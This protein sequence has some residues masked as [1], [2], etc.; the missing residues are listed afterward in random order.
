MNVCL[1][2]L[3]IASCGWKPR[4]RFRLSNIFDLLRFAL[5]VTGHYLLH[6]FRDRS[7][8]IIVGKFFGVKLLGYYTVAADLS[9]I[10][11]E[12]IIVFVNKVAYPV[13]VKLQDEERE[14]K[15]YLLKLIYLLSSFCMPAMI[16]MAVISEEIFLLILS[17]KWL[18]G[19]LLFRLFCLVA[20]GQSYMGI[21][22]NVLKAKGKVRFVF[23]YSLISAL[24]MPLSFLI[25]VR[26]G[27]MGIMCAWLTVY[28][29]V[30]T[31]LSWR[32]MKELRISLDELL[33]P[34]AFPLIGAVI[35]GVFMVAFRYLILSS[36]ISFKGMMAS[37]SVGIFVYVGFMLAFSSQ[38]FHDIKVI[39]RD[40]GFLK[41]TTAGCVGKRD[42]L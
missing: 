31:Y 12:K 41:A 2:I 33:R 27:I 1:S 14:L 9:R 18:P 5:P 16:G 11:I 23:N 36:E 20:I 21:I 15:R 17:D 39:T 37:I 32:T 29:I 4:F 25:A 35:M 38:I 24:L 6:Y 7:D 28:P 13:F 22:L 26:Y 30:L 42:S 19:L 34:I 8:A 40:L 3:I 10:V